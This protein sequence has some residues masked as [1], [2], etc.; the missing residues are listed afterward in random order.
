[1]SAA[2]RFADPAEILRGLAALGVQPCGVADDSRRT[3]GTDEPAEDDVV[4]I[5]AVFADIMPTSAIHIN[6]SDDTQNTE[7]GSN[8]PTENVSNQNQ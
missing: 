5:A 6:S 8:S 3:K 7:K 2:L 4:N 1:M